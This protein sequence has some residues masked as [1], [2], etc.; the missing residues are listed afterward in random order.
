VPLSAARDASAPHDG[1]HRQ[2]AADRAIALSS[3]TAEMGQGTRARHT[4]IVADE[5]GADPAVAGSS[6]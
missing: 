2:A 1:R 3:L 4:V 5:L 6:G